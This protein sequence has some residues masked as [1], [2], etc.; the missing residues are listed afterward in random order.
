MLGTSIVSIFSLFQYP[1]PAVA[2]LATSP[3]K[4]WTTAFET[5]KAKLSPKASGQICTVRACI[6]LYRL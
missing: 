6:H 1:P 4:N 3:Y 5:N 2:A